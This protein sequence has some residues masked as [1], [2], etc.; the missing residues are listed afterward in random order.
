MTLHTDIPHVP[1]SFYESHRGWPV[2]SRAE[3]KRAVCVH[4]DGFLGHCEPCFRVFIVAAIPP[5]FSFD[6]HPVCW[7]MYRVQLLPSPNHEGVKVVYKIKSEQ[8]SMHMAGSRACQRRN[9]RTPHTQTL[10]ICCANHSSENRHCRF[11]I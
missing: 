1:H 8:I 11:G 2:A 7:I 5:V 9:A 3:N 4:R 6:V 10:S